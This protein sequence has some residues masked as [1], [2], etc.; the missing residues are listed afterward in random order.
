MYVNA[1]LNAMGIA[2][3]PDEEVK[4]ENYFFID[5]IGNDPM[6]S[7]ARYP[8]IVAGN[9]SPE[10]LNMLKNHKIGIETPRYGTRQRVLL[11]VVAIEKIS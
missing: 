6:H 9:M 2:M 10:E 8:I 7:S 4:P 3:R 5:W 11:K 1:P